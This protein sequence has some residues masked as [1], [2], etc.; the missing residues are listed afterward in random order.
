MIRKIF[1][2][3]LR[4]FFSAPKVV[5]DLAIDD[6][7]PERWLILDATS[8]AVAGLEDGGH[9]TANN[10]PVRVSEGDAPA[11][12]T[13]TAEVIGSYSVIVR[14]RVLVALIREIWTLSWTLVGMAM[15]LVT[16]S[17][18]AQKISATLVLLGLV[19]H[20]MNLR[21]PRTPRK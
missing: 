12:S 17:G 5:V 1:E 6:S 13:E 8:L 16:L 14:R 18:D 7:V 10:L 3:I 20:T 15:V 9:A 21:L 11:C 2:G 19:L 4:P